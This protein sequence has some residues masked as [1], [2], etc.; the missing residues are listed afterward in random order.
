MAAAA[1]QR[2]ASQRPFADVSKQAS[3]PRACV[4]VL[5]ELRARVGLG[6]ARAAVCPL[7]CL[8]RL[9]LTQ[10]GQS[11]LRLELINQ[12]IRMHASSGCASLLETRL[13]GERTS[14]NKPKPIVTR[15]QARPS[16]SILL[17]QVYCYW[18]H[19]NKRSNV[20]SWPGQPGSVWL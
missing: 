3:Q 7:V 2:S 18:F 12:S 10:L 1:Q 19:P 11:H 16:A 20:T 9:P 17:S 14:G 4:L 5:F 6:R 15:P 8:A 13:G